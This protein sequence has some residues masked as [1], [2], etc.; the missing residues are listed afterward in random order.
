M[1][2]RKRDPGFPIA[3]EGK[4]YEHSQPTT[5]AHV[6]MSLICTCKEML[7]YSYDLID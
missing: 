4:G 5:I 7:E 6:G 3:K 1:K 2:I